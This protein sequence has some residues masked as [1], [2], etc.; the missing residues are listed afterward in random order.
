MAKPTVST[1]KSE[2]LP[3]QPL[4]ASR[5]IYVSNAAGT[6]RVPMREIALTDGT[7]AQVYDTS[8]PYSDLDLAFDIHKGLPDHRGAWIAARDDCELEP[9]PYNR[10]TNGSADPNHSAALQRAPLRAKP[11]RNVS[12]L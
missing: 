1:P 11:G 2:S 4:P 7:S 10:R 3:R 8:G 5:K 9:D 6:V 12:Q